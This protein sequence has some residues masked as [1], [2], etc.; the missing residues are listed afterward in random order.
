MTYYYVVTTVID[1]LA[2]LLLLRGIVR[3]GWSISLSLLN[4]SFLVLESLV[5]SSSGKKPTPE[6]KEKWA[7]YRKT[8]NASNTR[9]RR[10]AWVSIVS[11]TVWLALRIKGVV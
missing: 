10:S 11:T 6:E 7:E 5:D 1:V 3:G 9:L 4:F 2:F 8:L